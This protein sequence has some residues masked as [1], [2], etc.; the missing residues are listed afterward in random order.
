M[1]KILLDRGAD[2]NAQGRYSGNLPLAASFEGHPKEVQTLLNRSERPTS[3]PSKGN[4]TMLY[5]PHYLQAMRR[6]S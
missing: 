1:V 3:T 5:R 2:A 4:M 6:L